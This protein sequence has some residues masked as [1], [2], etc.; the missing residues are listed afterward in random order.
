[1]FKK[2]LPNL[3]SQRFTP[4]FSPQSFRVLALTFISL[5]HA[6]LIFVCGV[7]YPPAVSSCPEVSVRLSLVVWVH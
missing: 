5:V 4:V 3:R 7:R 1:M 6:E 2:A